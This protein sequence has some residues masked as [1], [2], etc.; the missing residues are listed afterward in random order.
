MTSTW[1]LATWA[2]T[3]TLFGVGSLH[4]GVPAE[5]GAAS[6]AEVA[7]IFKASCANCHGAD[8]QSGGLRLDTP[9][10][11][12]KGGASGAA[13]VPGKSDQS[14]MVSRI[15]GK[16]GKERMPL[17]F[18]PLSA[19]KISKI[20]AWID[21]GASFDIAKKDKHWAYVPPKRP[22]LPLAAD[23]WGRNPIDAFVLAR[24]RKEGLRPSPEASKE[25]LL[26][27]VSLDLTGLPPTVEELDA[28][29]ADKS[30]N[31]DERQVDRLLKSPHYG[32][33]MARTWLDL[34]RY[35]D[36][37]G[38]EKDLPRQMWV[39][40]DWVIGAFNKNMRF[41][42]FTIEQLAGDLLPKPTREQLIATGF[43]RNSML[44]DE[45]GIDAEEFRVV[46]VVD[47]VDAT[48]TTWMGTTMA[49]AQCHDHKYDPIPQRDYYRFFA[50]FNQSEDNGRDMEPRLP[51]PSPAQ[52]ARLKEL[53]ASLEKVE[54]AMKAGEDRA[55]AGLAAWEAAQRSWTVIKPQVV[56]GRK[57][58][59]TVLPD[60]SALAGGPEEAQETYTFFGK[61]DGLIT[62]AITG[63]RIEALP[64]PSLP[65]GSSGR[66]SNGSF[67]LG[68][69]TAEQFSSGAP[70]SLNFISAQADYTQQGH[71]PASLIGDQEGVGWAVDA[72]QPAHRVPHTV[73]LAFEAP[74]VFE[75]GDAIQVKL[76]HTVRFPNHNLGRF[77]ISF[78]TDP[79]L[80]LFR[81]PT[82]AV[83][84]LLAKRERTESEERVVRDF[85][86][87]VAPDLAPIRT[88]QSRLTKAR[89]ELDAQVPTTMVLRELAKPRP[90]RVLKRG[91]FRTPGD[92]V[93]PGVPRA[94]GGYAP[95]SNRLGLAKWL[96]SRQNPLTARVEVNRLWAQ[97]FGRG[98]V[99]TPEDFGVQGEK[100]SHP[101]LLDWLAVEFMEKG[102][103]IKGLLRLIVTSATYRQA[104]A[105]KSY[106]SDPQN[107]LL[108]RGPRFRVA[109]EE[110]RDVALRAS[111]LLT[112]KIGG[113]SVMPPQPPGVWENSFTF[114]DTKD[115]W[116]DEEGPNRYR[117]GL[118]TYWRR[119]APF[120]MM[121]TF[122]LKSRDTCVAKRTP[123]NTPLQALNVLNDP[124]FLES[125]A[126]LGVRL[127]DL[128][129]PMA[130]SGP[131]N[132]RRALVYGFR[133]C[134]S[135]TPHARELASLTRLLASAR[136]KFHA[137]GTAAAALLRSGGVT[138]KGR[139]TTEYAVWMV[140]ANALLNLDET[141]TKG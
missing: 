81:P 73:V 54:A 41:D 100:P 80:A 31:A 86:L 20:Q 110:V 104:A 22:A 82:H 95:S 56:A 49:C 21:A 55:L 109:A 36:T 27:R 96:V 74:V 84:T 97:C 28:F 113:P 66:N 136:S 10:G 33:K 108:S 106:A 50:F 77:R 71:D 93:T 140:V 139:L 79:Q 19:D 92:P 135:R 119:S 37:N 3:T 64:D 51:V 137:D 67:V 9:D 29:L 130:A 8:V 15:L 35:A 72:F 89:E 123:T 40:R 132:D 16:G 141:L 111:G 87:A 94:I 62:R 18:A 128:A 1:R 101:E 85:F 70:T 63:I 78:T 48:A 88:E 122:D 12:K 105:A 32:E 76:S 90:D 68:R 91:D 47:R 117:R 46:A 98:I 17:G 114:Y 75:P 65:T 57:T 125:A 120:P 103:D 129:D 53:K 4:A 14:L 58:T 134:T 34:A 102:W 118:Y 26:R 116:K 138:E 126:A 52:E 23:I 69:V 7:V 39:W 83:S 2:A 115:R 6:Y 44:N 59:F 24:L 99:A 5:E 121:L 112:P 38:Y 13:F 43:H 42:Q 25:T 11:L 131:G 127:G 133:A 45:G 61:P 107:V 124:A 60:G 30:P